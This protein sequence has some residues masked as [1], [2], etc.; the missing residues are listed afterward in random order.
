MSLLVLKKMNLPSS[1]RFLRDSILRA[2]Y[3][4]LLRCVPVPPRLLRA[5][6]SPSHL[7]ILYLSLIAAHYPF[8]RTVHCLSHSPMYFLPHRITRSL[9]PQIIHSLYLQTT[10]YRSHKTTRSRSLRRTCE[11]RSRATN[12]S[13]SPTAL[14]C[15]SVKRLPFPSRTA[16]ARRDLNGTLRRPSPLAWS[17]PRLPHDAAVLLRRRC[18]LPLAR[19]AAS[20]TCAARAS[21]YPRFRYSSSRP[22]VRTQT[23]SSNLS[24]KL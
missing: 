6:L 19:G 16:A 2:S 5:M 18:L 15:L 9:F 24:M 21:G 14:R 20:E 11:Y 3:R 23:L 22:C 4:L 1:L 7:I 10:L 13:L 17:I 12:P 8:Q